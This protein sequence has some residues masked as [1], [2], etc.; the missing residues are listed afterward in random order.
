MAS[1][2]TLRYT[3]DDGRLIRWLV[4]QCN[5]DEDAVRT[6]S[7]KMQSPYAA[8]QISRGGK[9]VWSGSRDKANRWAS[10]RS[11]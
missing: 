1:T 8:L 6:A 3:N 4:T 10:E 7:G 11:L 2:Y 9:L 5:D